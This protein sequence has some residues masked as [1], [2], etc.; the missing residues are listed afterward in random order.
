[1]SPVKQLSHDALLKYKS[2]EYDVFF[3]HINDLYI[4]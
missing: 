1:M 4:N 3:F 2:L